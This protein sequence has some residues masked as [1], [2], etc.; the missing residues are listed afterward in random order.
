MAG[1]Q[2]ERVNVEGHELTLTNLGKI[3]YPETGTTKAEVLEYY[4]A[5]APFLIP[6]AAN[7]PVTRKRWVNGVGTAEHPG[8]VFFQKNLEDSA[9]KWIPRA[10]IQ[11]SDHSNVY[12]LVNN[13]AT[14]T[15]MAQIASLEIHVPQWQVD[16]VREAAPARPLRPGPRPRARRRPSRV[17]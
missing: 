9:P 12:P 17:R 16:A 11:H 15:W 14:L 6:A 7:R 3:I 2:Q 13:L 5:V 10:A 8:Q 1:K 4:A